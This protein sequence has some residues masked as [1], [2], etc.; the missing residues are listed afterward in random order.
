M[1]LRH[2]ERA[3]HLRYQEVHKQLERRLSAFLMTEDSILYSSCFDA[4]GAC[5]RRC[6][7]KDDAVISDELNHASIIDGIRRAR[8]AATATQSG[9]W[10]PRG[11]IATSFRCA[12][13]LIATDGVFS[14]DGYVSPLRRSASWRALRRDGDG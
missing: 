9:T 14:M 13:R 11:T 8:P 3:L 5:S 4:N 7:A 2:G 6:S 10:A 12:R 1:G